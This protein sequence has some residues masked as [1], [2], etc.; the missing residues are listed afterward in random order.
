MCSATPPA[1]VWRRWHRK[2]S[3]NQKRYAVCSALAASA[4]PALVMAR[5]HRIEQVRCHPLQGS[6]CSCFVPTLDPVR[7]GTGT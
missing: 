1:Q 5:G 6:S 3:V 2:I 7:F 4:L